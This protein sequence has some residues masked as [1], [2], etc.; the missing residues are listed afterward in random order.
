MRALIRPVALALVVVSSAVGVSACE[1][2]DSWPLLGL[3]AMPESRLSPFPGATLL[4]Q[5][6]TPRRSGFIEVTTPAGVD[7]EFGTNADVWSVYAYYQSLLQP[8]G[9]RG[10]LGVWSK[11]GYAFDITIEKADSRPKDYENYFVVYDEQLAEDLSVTAPPG[12]SQPGATVP[13]DA[14]PP[15]S[16][17]AGHWPD[18]LPRS[19]G[20]QPVFRGDAIAA[21]A[22]DHSDGSSF[23]VGGYLGGVDGLCCHY[24]LYLFDSFGLPLVPPYVRLVLPESGVLGYWPPPRNPTSVVLEVHVEPSPKPC[25][26]APTYCPPTVDLD[27]L[28]WPE[29]P[30]PSKTLGTRADI[31]QRLTDAAGYTWTNGSATDDSQVSTGTSGSKSSTCWIT[32]PD[33]VITSMSVMS[34]GGTYNRADI[35]TILAVLLPVPYWQEASDWI[36]ATV[37][38]NSVHGEASWTKTFEAWQVEIDAVATSAATVDVEVTVTPA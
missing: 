14:T 22:R 2:K 12:E 3:Y 32:G 26:P 5:G 7:R 1:T 4:G 15:T 29:A 27:A 13:P 38:G 33:D 23:L 10:Q 25:A 35:D 30:L 19:L 28:V 8:L 37:G 18:G 21:Q 9:W 36:E 17:D 20:G 34:A 11:S 6:S 16:T 24:G 31:E